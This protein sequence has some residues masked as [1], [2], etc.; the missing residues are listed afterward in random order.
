MVAGKIPA[1]GSRAMVMHGTA[2]HTKGGLRKKDLKY[3]RQGRIVSAL[4]SETAKRQRRLGSYQLPKGSHKFVLGGVGGQVVSS[5]SSSR[6][7][8]SHRRRALPV[9]HRKP[10]GKA[11]SV[12]CGRSC[13]VPGLK[14]T[15]N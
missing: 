2:D 1:V 14:C 8:R 13:I 7:R 12:H 6:R 4:K 15:K 10:N 9:C 3:N 5:S 11:R